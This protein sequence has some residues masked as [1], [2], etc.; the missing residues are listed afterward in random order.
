M[1]ISAAMTTINT[2]ITVEAMEGRPPVIP[3]C[4]NENDIIIKHMTISQ[5]LLTY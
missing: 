3:A 4:N 2:M 1:E 5:A